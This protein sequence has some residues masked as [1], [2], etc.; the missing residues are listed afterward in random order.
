MTFLRHLANVCKAPIKR[1]FIVHYRPFLLSN[2][3]GQ[4]QKNSKLLFENNVIKR[5]LASEAEKRKHDPYAISVT[6]PRTQITPDDVGP[7]LESK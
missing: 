2:T 5:N 3:I 6:T 4:S 1:N 7:L